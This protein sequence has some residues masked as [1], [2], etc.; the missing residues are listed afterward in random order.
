MR[1]ATNILESVLPCVKQRRA[2]ATAPTRTHTA[3]FLFFFHPYTYIHSAKKAVVPP[4]DIMHVGVLLSRHAT[5]QEIPNSGN[6]I[7]QIIPNAW[8][9][10]LNL[11]L[12]PALDPI[13]HAALAPY[14]ATAGKHA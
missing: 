11:T 7:A 13:S 14:P 5:A 6:K 4:Y 10:G 1:G 12:E 2:N 8:A 3:A 9:G